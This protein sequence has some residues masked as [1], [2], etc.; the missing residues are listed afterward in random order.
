[1]KSSRLL[2]KS[3]MMLSLC[4]A[5]VQSIATMAE[6]KTAA[7]G[8]PEVRTFAKRLCLRMV[9]AGI[10]GQDIVKTMEDQL[11]GYLSITRDT[12][13]Y[14]ERI[15]RFWNENTN[16][17]IC[18]GRVDSATRE[19]EHLMKRAVALSLIG[20]VF[21]E[22]FFNTDELEFDY[23]AVEYVIPFSSNTG[24]SPSIGSV[25]NGAWGIGVPE[26]LLDYLN[27]IIADPMSRK[28]FVVEQVIDLRDS[29]KEEFNAKTA[30][31]LI[32]EGTLQP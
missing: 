14:N 15:I 12:S 5:L 19:S 24:Q 30:I 13:N 4:V 27:K 21:D 26:T 29:L 20:T 6:V 25:T 2:L 22:F 28:Q 10:R 31:E 17:F 3:I 32:S 11:L 18:K 7:V 16:D 1:M 23:N 9:T 8:A